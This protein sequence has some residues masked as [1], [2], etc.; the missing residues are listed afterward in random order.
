MDKLLHWVLLNTDIRE[1]VEAA[2]DTRIIHST[3]TAG[4]PDEAKVARQLATM[5][6]MEWMGFMP[7]L[8][9]WRE[10]GS[11]MEATCRLHILSRERQVR[12]AEWASLPD[13]RSQ[14]PTHSWGNY[15]VQVLLHS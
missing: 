14:R 6:L 4:L 13:T 8:S 12:V 11:L 7:Q 2:L 10:A 1:Q 9:V 15:R 5:N 3:R